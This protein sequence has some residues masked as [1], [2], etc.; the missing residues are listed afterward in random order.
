MRWVASWCARR[1]PRARRCPW[2]NNPYTAPPSPWQHRQARDR[3]RTCPSFSV[4]LARAPDAPAAAVTPGRRSPASARARITVRT[5]RAVQRALHALAGRQGQLTQR[6]LADVR[7]H[8]QLVASSVGRTCTTQVTL[9][10]TRYCGSATGNGSYV[11]VCSWPSLRHS[12]SPRSVA[13]QL[14]VMVAPIAPH[15]AEELWRKL[16]HE[17]TVAYEPFPVADPQYLVTDES[18]ASCRWPAAARQ[19][20]GAAGHQRGRAA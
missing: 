6:V 16:G 19:A 4:T 14:V 3:S 9:S 18:P 7:R 1:S 11:T 17:H 8:L 5:P 20:A 12:S 13:E 2:C 15:L 10:A